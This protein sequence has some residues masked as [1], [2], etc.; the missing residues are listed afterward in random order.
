MA[1]TIT[2]YSHH[3]EN[4]TQKISDTLN[5]TAFLKYKTILTDLNCQFDGGHIFE[6]LYNWKTL[7]KL[8]KKLSW[9][10][11]QWTDKHII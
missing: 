11:W 3:I 6:K 1:A 2:K 10:K 8:M 5:L 9:P 4:G 7:F